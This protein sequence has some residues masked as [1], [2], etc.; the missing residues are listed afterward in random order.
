MS[1]IIR[2]SPLNRRARRAM[3][4]TNGGV[5]PKPMVLPYI[6]PTISELGMSILAAATGRLDRDVATTTTT[7]RAA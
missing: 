3:R 6:R 7:G 2:R 4:R 1:E 5:V